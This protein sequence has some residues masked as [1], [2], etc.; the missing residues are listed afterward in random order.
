M[1]KTIN[2]SVWDLQ[3]L[4]NQVD[5]L[6]EKVKKLEKENKNLKLIQ[7]TNEKQIQNDIKERDELREEN[8]KLK[9]KVSELEDISKDYDLLSKDFIAFGEE[10]EN[11]KEKIETL[12]LRLDN[13]EKLNEEYRKQID[14]LRMRKE[15]LDENCYWLAKENE[16][17][18]SDLWETECSFWFEADECWYWKREYKRLKQ[19][20]KEHCNGYW[21]LFPEDEMKRQRKKADKKR[22]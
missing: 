1:S 20:I 3:Q 6:E 4:E 18:K 9:E 13:K 5:N 2:I 21:N 15:E 19:R 14:M 8:K 12:E 16:K 22:K 17:L 11:L 7:E 10:N